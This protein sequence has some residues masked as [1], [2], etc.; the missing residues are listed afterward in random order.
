MCHQIIFNAFE[1]VKGADFVLSNTV[2]E[3]EL[4]TISALK[5]KTPF[6]SIGPIFPTGFAKSLVPTSL[7]SESDCTQWLDT[8]PIGSV[9][10]VSFGSYAHVTKNDLVEIATGLSLSKVSFVWVLRAD[11]VSSEDPN[12]LPEGFREE[13]SDRSMIIPWCCQIQVLAHPSI[14]GFLT[15]CGW[16]SVIESMWAEVPMLCCPLYTDQFT[17]RKLVVDDW[18]IGI[19]LC[20]KKKIMREEVSRNVGRLMREKIGEDCRREIKDVKMELENALRPDGSSGMNLD[21]F[22]KDLKLSIQ[23]KSGVTLGQNNNR[24]SNRAA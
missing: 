13:I 2:Q 22:V 10:Y 23:K 5:T 7:W 14:G 17:N 24:L 18:K 16:N 11:I 12:P 21:Q 19:N 8:N 20:D 4:D 3:L 15:H 9:L 6:Y 1:D